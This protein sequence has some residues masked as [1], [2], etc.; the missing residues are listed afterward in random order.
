MGHGPRDPVLRLPPKLYQGAGGTGHGTHARQVSGA[1][2]S[3]HSR[4]HG[5]RQWSKG[6]RLR[7]GLAVQL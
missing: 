3:A 2:A 6:L 5:T 1:V 4:A 7:L